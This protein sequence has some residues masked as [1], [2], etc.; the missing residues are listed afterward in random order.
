MQ[1]RRD[2]HPG[3]EH[4]ALAL[5]WA[6]S[7]PVLPILAALGAPAPALPAAIQDRSGPADPRHD[8]RQRRLAA[9]AARLW[10]GGGAQPRL[11][12]IP[13]RRSRSAVDAVRARSAVPLRLGGGADTGHRC[14]GRTARCGRVGA[15][16]VRHKSG[17]LLDHQGGRVRAPDGRGGRRSGRSGRI[18]GVDRAPAPGPA[19]HA[20]LRPQGRL[21][22]RDG[23]GAVQLQRCGGAD[24]GVPEQA[25]RHDRPR[26]ICSPRYGSTRSATRPGRSPR[27]CWFWTRPT[28]SP[29]QGFHAR[30][31]TYI[32]AGGS[33]CP[34]WS[35]A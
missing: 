29:A 7:G 28:S 34:S 5:T 31:Q 20:E 22:Q 9:R 11:E 19:G 33:Y 4:I 14:A 15:D 6:D 24:D 23:A 8:E 32:C 18:G 25:V 27:R 3:A 30:R 13:L 2:V 26:S 35:A 1:I 16:R 10:R 21:Q 12:R 17:R